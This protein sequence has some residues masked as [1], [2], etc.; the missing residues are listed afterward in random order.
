MSEAL[1]LLYAVAVLVPLISLT[2]IATLFSV[3]SIRIELWD[4]VKTPNIIAGGTTV[5][6]ILIYA[7]SYPN[8][9]FAVLSAGFASGA[10]TWFMFRK[11]L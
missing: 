2:A 7:A 10:V 3:L 9:I 1:I 5:M 8:S 11:V 4:S 6:F